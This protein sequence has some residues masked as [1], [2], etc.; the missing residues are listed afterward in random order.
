MN[1]AQLLKQTLESLM[2]DTEDVQATALIT[3]DGLIVAS[4][5]PDQIEEARVG[6]MSATLLSLAA[7]ASRE[8]NLGEIKQILVRGDAS[9]AVI[10]RAAEGTLLLVITASTARL[11]L[12]FLDM[13][14]AVVKIEKAFC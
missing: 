10:Q 5:L 4:A 11:G 13:N 3:D 9:Y 7:R 2:S 12:I 6:G 8:L 1:R 14:R